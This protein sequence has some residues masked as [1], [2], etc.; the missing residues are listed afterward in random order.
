[1]MFYVFIVFCELP[2]VDSLKKQD[3]DVD[4]QMFSLPWQ[5]GGQLDQG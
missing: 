4:K 1:M 5:L 3:A 2:Q